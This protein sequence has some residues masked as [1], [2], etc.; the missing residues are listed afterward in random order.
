MKNLLLVFTLFIASNFM[1]QTWSD[2]VA[3]IFYDKCAKCHHTGGIAPMS[4]ITHAEVSPMAAAIAAA[5]SN[6]DMPPWPPDNNY[7]Q[8]VHDR[9]LSAQQKTTI[10]DWISNGTPEGNPSNTPPPPVFSSDA[11]LG[12]GDLSVRIPKYMSKATTSDDY[13]CFSIPSGLA[14]NRVIKSVEIVPGNREIVHHA[15]IYVDAGGVEVTDTV[16]SNCAG[17]SNTSTKLIAGYTPGA[18]PMILPSSAPLKLGMDIQAGSKI[19]FA[20]HYPAGSYGQFDSTQ[21]IFHFYP[22]GT[23]GV[24]QVSADPIIQNWSF[25]LPANQVTNVSAQYP[26]A[27]GLAYN[28]SLLSVFPHMHLLGES[29]KTYGIKTNGDTIKLANIPHWDFEWQD[30]YFFKNI[31]LAPTGSKLKAEGVYDNTSSNPHNPNNPPQTVTAGL[32]TSDEMFLVYFHYMLYQ[33]G[34]ENYDIENLMSASIEEQMIQQGEL[35]VAPNPMNNS[36]EITYPNLQSGDVVSLYIY[37]Y[38]GTCVRKLVQ[39]QTVDI[40][41][42]FEWDGANDAQTEVSRGVYFVSMKVNNQLVSQRILKL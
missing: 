4:F 22:L 9:S 29:I 35:R 40:P 38:K 13:V 11:I 14:Q 5:V 18:T 24:R 8:Y 31:Q 16:G 37:D 34:D 23:T 32:N 25:S 20:M 21:V 36:T 41:S 10:L 39:A 27:G 42:K 30:F 15:L 33:A 12:A 6:D 28:I 2:N 19:Y 3:Q 26:S 7:Q 17:P 1:A